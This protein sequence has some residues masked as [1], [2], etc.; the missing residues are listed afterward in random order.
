M[1]LDNLLKQYWKIEADTDEGLLF[2]H[3]PEIDEQIFLHK[4][5]KK[6]GPVYADSFEQKTE[7]K[8]L[9]E[10]KEFYQTYNGCRLFHSSINIYG[11]SIKASAPMDITLNN[12]NHHAKLSQNGKDDKDIVFIGGVGE[13]L[14]YY[15]QS[16]IDYPKIYLSKHGEVKIHKSFSSI[17]ELLTYFIL[18]LSQEYNDNGYR[19]HPLK[20]KV[21][22]Q[23]PLLANAFNGDIDW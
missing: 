13:Y 1:Y 18:A 4:L 16:E 10:L 11:F 19:K 7:I 6:I 12:H 22:Q 14:I 17:Q 3:M 5:Y 23:F 9:P 2:C 20:D 8:L 21:L 15:K